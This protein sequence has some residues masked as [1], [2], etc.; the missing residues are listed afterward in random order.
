MKKT[1]AARH[2]FT[3]V[4]VIVALTLAAALGA[5]LMVYM[6]RAMERSSDGVIGLGN[7]YALQGTMENI[8]EWAQTN[9]LAATS[10]SIG[11]EGSSQNNAFGEYDVIHNRFIRFSAQSEI[12]DV[13]GT[14]D[15]LKVTI[16]NDEGDRLALLLMEQ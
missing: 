13:T 11:A 8:R 10:T 3:L 16:R 2:G 1:Q 5:L 15:V 12:V 6:G 4:E 9:S 14:N 7:A